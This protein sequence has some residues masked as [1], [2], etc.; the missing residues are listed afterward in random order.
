MGCS[1][2]TSPVP[3]HDVNAKHIVSEPRSNELSQVPTV[4]LLPVIKMRICGPSGQ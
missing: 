2:P 4:P 3:A 1:H